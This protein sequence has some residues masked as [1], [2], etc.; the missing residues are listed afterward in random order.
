MVSYLHHCEEQS[1]AAIQLLLRHYEELPRHLPGK[2]CNPVRHYEERRDA[3]IQ[4][5]IMKILL[6]IL[7]GI[8]LLLQYKIWVDPKG[9]SD[10]WNLH[11]SVKTQRLDNSKL[12]ERNHQVHVEIQDLKSGQDGIEGRARLNLGMVQK[13]ETFYQVVE[14]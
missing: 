12:R 8:I 14:K 5:R 6:V 13:G 11:Q 1:D 7:I 3:A 10:L 4:D 2:T 9:I